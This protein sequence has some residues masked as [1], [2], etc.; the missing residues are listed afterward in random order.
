MA[1][2]GTVRLSDALDCILKNWFDLRELVTE[3]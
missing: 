2:K 3:C 1:G